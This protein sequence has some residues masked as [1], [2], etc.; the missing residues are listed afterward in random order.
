VAFRRDHL[1]DGPAALPGEPVDVPLAWQLQLKHE[2]AAMS[3]QD[4][5]QRLR[6]PGTARPAAL[7]TAAA[8]AEASLVPGLDQA[9]P[10]AV[11]LLQEGEA[12]V[13]MGPRRSADG[14][15]T[16]PE[17]PPKLIASGGQ[18]RIEHYY[19]SNDHPPAHAHVN[20][21]GPETRIGQNGQPLAGDP[22]LTQDQRTVVDANLAAIR[23]ALDKIGRWLAFQERA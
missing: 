18:V 13:Q 15:Y 9:E 8:T 20:G 14:A 16:E 6:P 4:Q 7:S 19:R 1:L 2:L 3:Y 17:L 10:L 21:G 11:Q 12:P 23:R 22:E 5:L